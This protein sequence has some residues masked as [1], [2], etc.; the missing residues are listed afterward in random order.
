MLLSTQAFDQD[1]STEAVGPQPRH[2][3]LRLAWHHHIFMTMPLE[4]LHFM[5]ELSTCAGPSL[6]PT[7]IHH[8]SNREAAIEYKDSLETGF[9]REDI[10]TWCDSLR[11][12]GYVK[13]K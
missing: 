12:D 7:R 1:P 11:K 3:L 13:K 6:G 10:N 8:P 4:D 5:T 9:V 2:D